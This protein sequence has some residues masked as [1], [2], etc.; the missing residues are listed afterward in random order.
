[1][2]VVDTNV[3]IS[4]LLFGGFPERVF[5]AGLQDEIQLLTIL[6]L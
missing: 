5:L 3:L 6:R 2:R 1:V 4:G